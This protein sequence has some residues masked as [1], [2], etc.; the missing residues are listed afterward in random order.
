MTNHM[1]QFQIPFR[2]Y[3]MNFMIDFETNRSTTFDLSKSRINS[4][5]LIS[6]FHF[7]LFEHV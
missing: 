5:S 1:I 7:V 6:Y 3:I 4:Q 2:N